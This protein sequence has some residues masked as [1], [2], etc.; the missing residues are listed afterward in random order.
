MSA[1]SHP[2]FNVYQIV[3]QAQL[4]AISVI[5]PGVRCQQVDDAARRV[6]TEAG[7][8]KFSAITPVMLSVLKS[9]KNRVFHRG[10]LRRYSQ[11]CY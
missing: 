3:L 11:V 1:E 6:I 5:R 10:T 2:L 8:G 9:M 4:A 7:Y